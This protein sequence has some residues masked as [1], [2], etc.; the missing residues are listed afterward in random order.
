MNAIEMQSYIKA[1]EVY[2]IKISILR[3]TRNNRASAYGFILVFGFKIGIIEKTVAKN[4][5][6]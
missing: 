1:T 5:S 2:K 3:E 6:F 4:I